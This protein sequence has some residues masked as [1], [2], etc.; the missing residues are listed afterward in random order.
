SS[1]AIRSFSSTTSLKA[2]AT[3][4]ATPVHSTGRRTP[5]LPL[6]RAVRALSRAIISLPLVA[7]SWAACMATPGG[8]KR[9]G[10]RD[11]RRGAGGGGSGGGGRGGGG[12]RPPPPAGLPL[13]GAAV[14]P[15]RVVRRNRLGIPHRGRRVSPARAP[16]RRSPG[17]G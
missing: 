6:R 5:G 10:G 14:G 1:P 4:P 17:G 11:G 7:G 2:S 8:W 13:A 3:L 9:G 15:A 16:W 12:G